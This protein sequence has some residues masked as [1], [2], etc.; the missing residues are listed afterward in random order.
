MDAELKQTLEAMQQTLAALAARVASLEAALAEEAPRASQATMAAAPELATPSTAGAGTPH[1]RADD[2]IA[3]EILLAISAAVA[4]FLGERAHVRQ[5]RLISSQA[6]GQ[7]GR[8]N[9]QAS[10]TLYR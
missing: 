7:Q 9:V 2:E 1:R 6:W 3:P 4:A 10:H 5:I 8:V